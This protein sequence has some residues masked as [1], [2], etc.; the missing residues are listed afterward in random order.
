M[1]VTVHDR[2]G[3]LSKFR[4]DVYATLAGQS[5]EELRCPRCNK[6]GVIDN[7]SSPIIY[8]V[9]GLEAPEPPGGRIVVECRHCHLLQMVDYY[10]AGPARHSDLE[11]SGELV[12]D[13]GVPDTLDLIFMDPEED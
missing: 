4:V 11:V 12:T 1:N 6:R 3:N 9:E 10:Y 7:S 2:V 5:S 8:D 13:P